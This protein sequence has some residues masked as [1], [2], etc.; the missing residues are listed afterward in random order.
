MLGVDL[1]VA[2]I[3]WTVFLAVLA[4]FIV[5]S[6]RSTLLVVV[7]A[8]FFSYL[9]Y[10]LVELVEYYKPRRFPRT[11][12]IALVFLVVILVAGVVGTLFGN[13]ITDEA[14]RLSQQL[15]IL[16]NPTNIS[17]R[18]PLPSF[19]EP[20]RIN[21]CVRYRTTPIWDRP[22]VTFCATSWV[23]CYARSY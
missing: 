10:P 2:K 13:R 4:L 15:P 21:P 8:V 1:R 19:L 7:F 17:Q 9:L 12:S 5:Y 23:G 6:V 20:Q 22:G 18:I 3:V 11:V 14:V 16:L